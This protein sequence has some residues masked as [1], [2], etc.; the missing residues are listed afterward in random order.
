MVEDPLDAFM[1]AEVAPEIAAKELAEEERRAE[2][3]RQR[4]QARAVRT[5]SRLPR[6]HLTPPGMRRVPPRTVLR[7]SAAPSSITSVCRPSQCAWVHAFSSPS[8]PTLC[9]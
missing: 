8:N 2:Q 9:P 7:R 4:L 5:G 6:P 3:R 1:A